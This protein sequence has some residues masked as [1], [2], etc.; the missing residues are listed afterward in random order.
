MYCANYGRVYN[1]KE[2]NMFSLTYIILFSCFFLLQSFE[3]LVELPSAE[4]I[5]NFVKEQDQEQEELHLKVYLKHYVLYFMKLMFFVLNTNTIDFT[6]MV[7]FM[8]LNV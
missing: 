2:L 4:D 7:L 3:D 5:V 6:L 1:F 8:C